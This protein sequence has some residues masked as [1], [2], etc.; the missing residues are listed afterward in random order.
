[1]IRKIAVC[2]I[3]NN[4][5]EFLLQKKTLDHLLSPGKWALFGGNIESDESPKDAIIRE[6]NEEI[7]IVTNPNFLFEIKNKINNAA[8]IVSTYIETI[9]DISK[10]VLNEG[11]GF[12]FFSEK[13]LRKLEIAP[14]ILDILEE[15]F[16][17][18]ILLEPG[19]K[20]Y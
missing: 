2:I 16:K 4:K 6:L 9:D 3:R 1:M 10:I 8:Q 13:E 19:F 12:A 14:D 11:A 17:K 20:G 7:G 15:Y 18:I 5:G